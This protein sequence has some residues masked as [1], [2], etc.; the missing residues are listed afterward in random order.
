MRRFEVN[1]CALAFLLLLMLFGGGGAAFAQ[2][3]CLPVTEQTKQAL[4]R[5]VHKKL[6]LP[7]TVTLRVAEVLDVEGTCYRRLRF[8]ATG[9]TQGT[10]ME[11]FLSPDRRF[12]MRDLADSQ[13]DP[14]EEEAK[15]AKQLVAGLTEGRF[16]AR[17]PA[18]APVTIVVF[19]DFQ[20]PFCKDSAGLLN[21]VAASEGNKVRIIFRHLPLTA[22]HPWARHAAEAAACAQFQSDEAFW[23]LHDLI[24][25]NQR[26][27]TAANVR[28]KL[29][30]LA[31][32][33]SALDADRFRRCVAD[34]GASALVSR[35]AQFAA[36]HNIAAT[37]TIFI[38]GKRAQGLRS[39]EQLRAL[40]RQL[41]AA[42]A[43]N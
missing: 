38:N 41:T 6:K 40:V 23:G 24:F 12:L 43:D 19:S 3:K 20:C 8:A 18:N 2:E 21:Q 5:Y 27:F 9:G 11:L 39:A 14:E 17:G 1:L 30:D 4:S 13:L 29:S 22:I 31:Q 37:P 35:D 25:E 33:V 42:P 26:G 32:T 28:A 36:T 10:E 15:K 16:A 34:S 7:A